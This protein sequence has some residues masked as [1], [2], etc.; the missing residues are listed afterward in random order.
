MEGLVG[1]HAGGAAVHGGGDAVG[2]QAQVR[3]DPLVRGLG[4]QVQMRIHQPGADQLP[5]AVHLYL[6]GFPVQRAH[7]CD[8]AAGHRHIRLL[9]ACADGV[10]YLP[11]AKNH[12]K[13]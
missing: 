12:I 9:P 10:K 6:S 11:A 8:A 2:Q 1:G 13:Q 4:E 5:G 3:R 7:G